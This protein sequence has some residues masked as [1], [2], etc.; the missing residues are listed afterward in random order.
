MVCSNAILL[1][2]RRGVDAQC[3]YAAAKQMQL[4]YV[5]GSTAQLLV[6]VAMFARIIDVDELRLHPSPRA[7]KCPNAACTAA[8]QPSERI[9]PGVAP[10]RE[11]YARV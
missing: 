6:A 9:A 8:M 4:S 5:G 10:A 11:T 1:Q 2:S 3:C 7:A